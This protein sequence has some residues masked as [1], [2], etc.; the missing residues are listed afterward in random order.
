VPSLTLA[1]VGAAASSEVVR[2]SC[3]A[4][5]DGAEA[6]Q[7]QCIYGH[8]SE[9]GRDLYTVLPTAVVGF[10][11]QLGIA[12]P[13]PAALNALAITH[14]NCSKDLEVSCQLGS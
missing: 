13:M 2:K 5:I 6:I 10:L 8:A 11:S 1:S 9:H 12:M 7:P 14:I 3:E 4:F